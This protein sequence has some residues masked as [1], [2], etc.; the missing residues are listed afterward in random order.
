M[1]QSAIIILAAGESLRLGKSKQLLFFR[2]LTLLR[3]TALAATETGCKNIVAVLG[4]NAAAHQSEI[5]DLPVTIVINHQWKRGMG[6][7]IKVGLASVL[8]QSPTT[9]HVIVLVCDQPY[10]SASH[11]VGLEKKFVETK[12]SI[13]ASA[14]AGTEGVPALFDKTW[15][16]EISQMSDGEGAKNILFKNKAHVVTVPFV[17]GGIDIDTESDVENFL[18]D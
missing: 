18:N 9:S 4:A 7:S 12:A 8:Q 5:D 6:C 17:N 16:E 3:R 11:L 14:Y 13:V 1:S 15:F 2:G 10:V